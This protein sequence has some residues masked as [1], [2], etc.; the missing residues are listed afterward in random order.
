[1][2]IGKIFL[3]SLSILILYSPFSYAAESLLGI[4]NFS[5]GI[6]EST[7]GKQ[8]QEGLEQMRSHLTTLMSDINKQLTEIDG[9]LTNPE[10]VDSLSPA[11]E[12]ELKGKRQSLIEEVYRYE[13]QFSQMMNQAQMRLLQSMSNH[14]TDA[15]ASVAKKKNLSYVI[16]KEA[17]FYYKTESDITEQV[18][19][20]M[21]SDFDK[22]NQSKEAPM[23][24]NTP[25]TTKPGAKEAAKGATKEEAKSPPTAAAASSPP[26]GANKETPKAPQISSSTTTKKGA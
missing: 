6:S 16:N 9:K 7:Y 11:A 23:P 20:E 2:K 12:E 14:T 17:C 18:I 3:S 8:E 22:N 4:V 21:N 13:H 25:A 24:P 19:A 10:V 1:M 26:K 5:R 15:S